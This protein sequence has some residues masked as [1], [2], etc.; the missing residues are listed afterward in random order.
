MFSTVIDLIVQNSEL[1]KDPGVFKFNFRK[2]DSHQNTKNEKS[3]T[4]D[5]DM[6]VD[7]H[8]GPTFAGIAADARN[9]EDDETVSRFL[10]LAG[11]SVGNDT[12][13]AAHAYQFKK[14]LELADVV[15]EMLVIQWDVEV[16]L[17]KKKFFGQEETK[18]SSSFSTKQANLVPTENVVAWLK[19]LRHDFPTIP[20]KSSTQHQKSNLSSS[21]SKAA[22]KGTPHLLSLLKSIRPAHSSIT[23]GVVGPPNVGKSSLINSIKR[24]K[25]C[26]VGA[27]PGET[28]ALKEVVVERGIRVVDTPGIIWGD[29]ESGSDLRNVWSLEG[30]DDPLSVVES[31]ASRVPSE[32]LQKMYGI[33]QFKDG[34]EL[35]MMVALSRGK[36]GKGGKP[37]LQSAAL[38]VLHDWNIGKIPYFTQPPSIHPSQ[39]TSPEQSQ[40]AD[41]AG[42]NE[43]VNGNDAAISG[44]DPYAST[45]IVTEWGQSFDL[46]GLWSAADA[47]V[48]AEDDGMEEMEAE[49]LNENEMDD[50]SNIALDSEEQDI[51]LS[52]ENDP[53][54]LSTIQKNPRSK[55]QKP[56]HEDEYDQALMANT[57]PLSRKKLREEAKRNKKAKNRMERLNG[58]VMEQDT[59]MYVM[60]S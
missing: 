58:G 23:I 35:A 57:N 50:E 56:S 48:L 49:P 38:M 1:K 2:K 17:S 4:H 44:V 25:V 6:I 11:G 9:R 37:D 20:F 32:T 52:V 21:T 33:P 28:K 55:P 8:D 18:E 14:V 53:V 36:L 10:K 41:A 47:D 51:R 15:L 39:I 29:M 42:P 54:G 46:E 5:G 59:E 26:T 45:S 31:I 13:V 30:L 19:Y 40:L 24:E 34:T 60:D 27:K 16:D 12:T 22:S 43:Q 3:K 7:S